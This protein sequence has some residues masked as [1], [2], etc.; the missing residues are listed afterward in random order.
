[1]KKCQRGQTS[2]IQS[3]SFPKEQILETSSSSHAF[4]KY[5]SSAVRQFS[6]LL[7]D[8]LFIQT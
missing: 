2:S 7:E 6:S 5:Y 8:I 1:M 3:Q 4:C